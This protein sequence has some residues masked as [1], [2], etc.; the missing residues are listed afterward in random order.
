MHESEGDSYLFSNPSCALE[1][2][3]VPLLGA[4]SSAQGI[5]LCVCWLEG[6]AFI[7]YCPHHFCY[8]IS[9][10]LDVAFME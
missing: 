4:A 6:S 9:K 5:C 1:S 3:P 2:L 10:M 8:W 7:H